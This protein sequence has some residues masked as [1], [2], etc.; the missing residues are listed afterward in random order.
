MVGGG[1]LNVTNSTFSGNS[2]SARGG[3]IRNKGTVNV[4]NSTFFGNSAA[5]DGG[6]IYNEAGTGDVATSRA[7]SWPRH[8]PAATAETKSPT[9]AT[10]SM[11][12][13]VAAS[14][15]PGARATSPN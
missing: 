12:T 8:R 9:A 15:P 4:T 10:T 13:E 7:Q 14:A 3:A 2:A 6:D 11:T 1:V 5:V